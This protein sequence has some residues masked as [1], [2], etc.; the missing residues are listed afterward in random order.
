MRLLESLDGAPETD[1]RNHTEDAMLRAVLSVVGGH[2]DSVILFGSRGRAD[3]DLESDHDLAV[4]MTR[5]LSEEAGRRTQ[6]AIHRSLRKDTRTQS[7]WNTDVFVWGP[8][9]LRSNA[10]AKAIDWDWTRVLWRR[11]GASLPHTDI[12]L[13][14]RMYDPKTPRKR[15]S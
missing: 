5:D 7:K 11:P 3:H 12:D 15:K 13:T 8:S 14:R 10:L 2:V 1:V 4:L 6:G 9:D